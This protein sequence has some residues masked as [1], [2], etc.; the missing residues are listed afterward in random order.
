MVNETVFWVAPGWSVA[1][2]VQEKSSRNRLAA[3]R[4]KVV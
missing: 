1:V 3:R 2:F 4:V